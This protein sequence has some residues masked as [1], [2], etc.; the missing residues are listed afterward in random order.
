MPCKA[1]CGTAKENGLPH[2]YGVCVCTSF[3]HVRPVLLVTADLFLLYIQFSRTH[4]QH[5]RERLGELDVHQKEGGQG[6]FER[7]AR[8]VMN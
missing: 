2:Y 6:P 5:K 7:G 8:N 1:R 4:N 3:Y